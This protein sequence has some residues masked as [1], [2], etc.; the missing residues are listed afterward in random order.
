MSHGYG[1]ASK[2]RPKVS[3]FVTLAQ[4]RRRTTRSAARPGYQSRQRQVGEHKDQFT[5]PGQMKARGYRPGLAAM[6]FRHAGYS[7]ST[8]FCGQV[9]YH[10]YPFRRSY[11]MS[12]KF[13][14][15]SPS[16]SAK[17]GLLVSIE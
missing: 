17:T 7:T 6:P 3:Q 13:G 1:Y 10:A 14:L 16:R 15:G 4:L 11:P 8:S 2:T 12:A 5:A 9:P